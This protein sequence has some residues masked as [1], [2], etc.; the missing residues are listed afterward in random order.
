MGT[1]FQVPWARLNSW[2][3]DLARLKDEG[4]TV[5]AMELTPGRHG[6][7]PACRTES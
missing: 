2:P 7:R 5:A 6:P 3:Q 1:V 4:F